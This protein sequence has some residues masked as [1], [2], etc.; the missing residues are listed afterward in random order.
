[1]RIRSLGLSHIVGGMTLTLL[2]SAR[3][4]DA[5]FLGH[6]SLGAVE[7]YTDNLRFSQ[8]PEQEYIS[9]LISRLTVVH[10]SSWLPEPDFAARLNIAGAYFARRPGLSNF[11]DDLGL[12]A[13]YVYPY[14]PRLSFLVSNR[15]ERQGKSRLIDA[16]GSMLAGQYGSRLGNRGTDWFDTVSSLGGFNGSGGVA[17]RRIG[18]FARGEGIHYD[19]SGL[20]VI[21]ERLENHLGA[22]ASFEYSPALTFRAGYCW[23]YLGFLDVGGRETAHSLEFEGA[24]QRWRRHRFL[25]RYTVSLI[26]SRDGRQHLIHN[27]EGGDDYM[28]MHEIHLTP[29]FTLSLSAGLVLVTTTEGGGR[30]SSTRR[31]PGFRLENKFDVGLTKVWETAVLQIGVRRGLTSSLG[32]S[33]PSLTTSFF[34]Y[35]SV[36]L[37]RRLSGAVNVGYSLYD[38]GD[39]EF[40]T[41]DALS[42][43]QYWLTNWLAAN[44]IYSY[45]KLDPGPGTRGYAFLARGVTNGNSV[46]IG[47]S[48]MFDVWPDFRLGRDTGYP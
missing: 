14:S 44:L 20:V 30:F 34:G 39:A 21:G 1:M 10:K 23:N 12:R 27:F 4:L 28:R 24:D 15:F 40:R 42:T 17:C 26:R 47:F 48:M 9:R 6:L 31:G 8:S 35:F 19:N 7:E 22:G 25:A 32:V 18:S 3:N 16:D 11:G 2:C 5:G 36:D 46:L 41:L 37:T 33:G 13:A 38:T 29:T 43:L 45:R